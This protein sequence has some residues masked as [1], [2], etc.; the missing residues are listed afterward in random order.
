MSP[1]YFIL[2]MEGLHALMGKAEALGLFKGA[3]V[4]RN[5]M[6]ISHLLYADDVIFFG[7]WSWVNAHN[8][9]SMLRCFFL[10]SG[11]KINIHKSNILG[12]GVTDVEARLLSIGGRLSLIK[13]VLGNL[14]TYYM[15]VYL[16]S[17]SV[18][19]KLELMRN[20]FFIG[21]DPDETKMTWVKWDRCLTSR[22]DGDLWVRVIQSIHGVEGG[23]NIA[24]RSLKCI[25]WCSLLSS[26][27]SLKQK[28]IDLI[29]FCSRKIGNVV[30]SWFWE[31]TWFGDQP[32]KA[33]FPRIYLLD[34]DKRCSIASRVRL[35]DW[36][37][38]L[39]RNP[40][41][42]VESFQFSALKD[43]TENI[44][45]TNQRN[46]WQWTL[47]SSTGF[48]VASVRSLV[49]SHML[50]TDLWSLL[51]KWWELDIPVCSNIAEWFEW[52][53]SLRVPS[54]VRLFLEGVAGTLMWS[55]WN[56]RNNLIFSPCPPKKAVI[57]D[58]IVSQSFLWLSSRNPSCNF[59]WIGWLKNP[60]ASITSM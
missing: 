39:R 43:V 10:I 15:S 58:S 19:K 9:I 3:S 13:S 32:L 38:V 22:K 56:Y 2:A 11:L 42:G 60:I 54:K 40:R 28:G 16:M 18:C 34:T 7:E 37:S 59:S 20:R 35:I 29:S 49:D 47:D 26:I 30:D 50:D 17:V 5:N 33:V 25:T 31:D 36:S 12:I 23:I 44:S 24:N 8:L 27:D 41:G 4:G 53:D 51:A 45:L 52:L 1:F 48:S 55:I 46:S 57:W 6:S 14:P 21:G